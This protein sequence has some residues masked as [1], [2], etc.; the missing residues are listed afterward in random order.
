MHV[1][2]NKV[3]FLVSAVLL[4]EKRQFVAQMLP[5]PHNTNAKTTSAKLRFH[6]SQEGTAALLLCMLL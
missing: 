1:Y 6:C 4:L 3:I 2:I 5:N